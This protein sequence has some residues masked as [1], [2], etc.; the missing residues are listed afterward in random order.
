MTADQF[1]AV[2]DPRKVKNSTGGYEKPEN[3]ATET[4]PN[5]LF[6]VKSKLPEVTLPAVWLPHGIL[7]ISNSEILPDQT[8]GG[9]GPFAGQVF[10][11]DQGQSRVMRVVME[12]VKGIPGRSF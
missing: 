9:F 10:V 8:K 5:T 11:G 6:A 12:K 1:N 4:N 2:V 7:G 3:I